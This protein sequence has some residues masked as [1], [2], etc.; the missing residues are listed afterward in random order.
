MVS[1]N[2]EPLETAVEEGRFRE[3][4]LYRL[5]IV[6]IDMPSLKEKKR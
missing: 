1:T 3:D 6:K 2:K 5:N 4:L